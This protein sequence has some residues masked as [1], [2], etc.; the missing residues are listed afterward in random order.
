MVGDWMNAGGPSGFWREVVLWNVASAEEI[1]GELSD[2]GAFEVSNQLPTD[3]LRAA[4]DPETVVFSAGGGIAVEG[5]IDTAA[6]RSASFPMPQ[7][8]ARAAARSETTDERVERISR[9]RGVD[10]YAKRWTDGT[11]WSIVA[12]NDEIYLHSWIE[13][14]LS[15]SRDS[16]ESII[17]CRIEGTGR[18]AGTAPS[19]SSTAGSRGRVG[20]PS[21]A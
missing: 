7:I 10:L 19:R 14:T 5:R 6:L 15:A 12:M 17:D 9:H 11:P 16:V 4:T 20:W 3:A 2:S 13:E 1:A 8:R 18:P 21:P